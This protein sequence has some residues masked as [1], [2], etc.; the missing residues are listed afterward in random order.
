LTHDLA[1]P[2]IHKED[3]QRI[4]VLLKHFIPDMFFTQRQDL[5]EDEM[6]KEEGKLHC[7]HSY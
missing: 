1:F 6:D 2:G 7:Y 4:K 5:S 3:K